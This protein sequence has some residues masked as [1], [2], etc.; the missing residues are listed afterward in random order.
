MLGEG[1][2]IEQVLANLLSNAIKY[3][4][5][6]GTVGGAR[7]GEG[8]VHAGLGDR[9]R[10]RHP[11]RAAGADLPEVLPR[12]LVRHP[13]DRRHG[14]R[15]RAVPRDRRGARRAASGSRASEGR[16]S[17]FWFELPSGRREGA[18]D[19]TGRVLVVEDDPAAAAL[20]AEYLSLDGF[21]VEIA[22]DRRAR[23]GAGAGGAAGARLPRHGAAR[24]AS[25]AGRCSRSSART[26][27][28]PRCPSSSAPRT[29]AATAPPRWARATSSR[30]RS[31]PSCCAPRWAG[32]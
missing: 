29:T 31:A 5:E 26:R 24:R 32:C 14:P 20:M 2:R 10:P 25:T 21:R 1:G 23:A 18:G 12:R 30:S 8:R 27:R 4:P 16:G 13:R 17:T 6:G 22:L 19:T 28:R 3:S 15:A 11:A 7:P 9:P